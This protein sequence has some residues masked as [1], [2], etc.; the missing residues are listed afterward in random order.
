MADSKNP[1]VLPEGYDP[2]LAKANRGAAMYELEKQAAQRKLDME[3]ERAKALA[4]G[5]MDSAK[6]VF[7]T[8]KDEEPV[9]KRAGGTVRS[10]ASKR[11][12]GIATKGKTRGRI[13]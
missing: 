2:E 12:D 7:R 8:K 5:L 9:K 11:A 10:S 1:P 6:N 3:D 4:K 13:V